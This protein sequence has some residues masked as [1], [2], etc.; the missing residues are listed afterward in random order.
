[1]NA[2]EPTTK[3]VNYLLTMAEM[4]AK[5]DRYQAALEQI[6]GLSHKPTAGLRNACAIARAALDGE[7]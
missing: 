2:D 6:A 3:T 1:M 7:A 5:H 4:I